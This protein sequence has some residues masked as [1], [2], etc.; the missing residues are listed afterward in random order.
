MVPV[1]QLGRIVA[2]SSGSIQEETSLVI[3]EV[4]SISGRPE[5]LQGGDIIMGG[6]R[7]E[8]WMVNV[9][10]VL[11]MLEIKGIIKWWHG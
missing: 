4:F 7:V 6:S 8:E 3:R 1:K 9:I 5:L 2:H 10:I 11:F